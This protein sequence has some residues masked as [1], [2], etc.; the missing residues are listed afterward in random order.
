MAPLTPEQ[1]E[2]VTSCIPLAYRL[3]IDA[4]RRMPG[5]ARQAGD[6][7]D[8]AAVAMVGLC[9]AA[10]RYDH[11]RRVKFVTFGCLCAKQAIAREIEQANA[12]RR[13]ATFE[14]LDDD[15][16]GAEDAPGLDDD[17]RQ[18]ILDAVDQLPPRWREILRARF[19]EGKALR[20]IAAE[21][22]VTIQAVQQSH[23]AAIARLR[24]VLAGSL[25]PD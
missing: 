4:H 23:A 18:L 19:M 3:A 17:E 5:L 11:G 25:A 12:K 20:E 1:Q 2:L 15:V 13:T 16:H 9:R 7:S 21:L 24:D 8:L 6:V 14:A 10:A 22:G